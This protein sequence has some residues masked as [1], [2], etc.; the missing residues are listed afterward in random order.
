MFRIINKISARYI[1]AATVIFHFLFPLHLL[2]QNIEKNDSLID[3]LL[4]SFNYPSVG[5]VFV[6]GKYDYNSQ[7]MFIPVIEMFSILGIYV[8]PSNSGTQGYING[9]FLIG[10]EPYSFDFKNYKVKVGKVEKIFSADDMFESPLDSYASVKIFEEMFQMI[11]NYSL[12]NL[13]LTLNTSLTMPVVDKSSR[14]A[15]RERIERLSRSRSFYPLEY[16]RKRSLLS[17]GFLDYNVG[18][19]S[20]FQSIIQQDYTF[21]MVGGIEALGGEVQASNS[22]AYSEVGG[23]SNR[24]GNISWKYSVR[25]TPILSSI[26]IGQISTRGLQSQQINGVSFTNNPIEPRWLYGETVVDGNAQAD[27]EVELYLNNELIDFAISDAQGYYRFNVPLRYGTTSLRTQ[28]YTTDGQLIVNQKEIQIPF[29]FLPKGNLSYNIQAGLIDRD[30]GIQNYGETKAAN[31]DLSYG[32]SN[33][34]TTKV[35]LEYSDIDVD[36]PLIYGS[37]TARVFQQYLLN[38]EFVPSS[39]YRAQ[40]SVVF[41]SNHSISAVYTYFDGISRFNRNGAEHQLTTNIYSPIPLKFLN[42]GLRVSADYTKISSFSETRLRTDF[43]SQLGPFNL[44]L[45]YSD[46]L[47]ASKSSLNLTGG[48]LTSALTYKFNRRSGLKF[49]AGSFLR[50]SMTYNNLSKSIQQIDLQLSKTVL[51]RGQLSLGFSRVIPSKQSFLQ[52]GFNI[53]LGG[54]VRSST[55]G[56]SNFSSSSITQSFRGSIGYD[57]NFN[58]W[59]A[60]DRQQVS[61]SG[62]SVVMFVDNDNDGSYSKGDEIIP[63]PAIKLNRTA[64]VEVSKKGIV[65]LSQ[66]QSNYRYNLEI[67]RGQIPNPLFLPEKDKFSFIADPNQFKT[68]EIPFYRSGVI[69]GMVYQNIDGNEEGV[70]GL[71]LFVSGIDRDFQKTIRTFRGGSF[72]SLDIPPGRYTL[73]VDP[74]QLGYTG[75]VPRDGILEFQIK[76]TSEG[77]FLNDLEIVLIPAVPKDEIKPDINIEDIIANLSDEYQAYILELEKSIREA[78]LYY[79]SAQEAYFNGDFERA[80]NQIDASL[81]LYRTDYGIALKGTIHYLQGDEIEANKLWDEAYTR[82]P[83]IVKPSINDLK[84]FLRLKTN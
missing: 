12:N 77:D 17:A 32:I 63:Y 36:T 37:A 45:N 26:Q 50:T 8:E 1:L 61:K 47:I 23:W 13:S 25:D 15:A 57:D 28:V 71:R 83:N 64:Q 5:Q 42:A 67:D 82:N 51:Q 20:Q 56:R 18:I 4:L 84:N 40:S 39:L 59:Q 68:I 78:L 48:T 54:K 80:M 10:G 58:E 55:T 30:G 31:A 22:F 60:V 19:A 11:F 6:L 41:N 53:D 52:A 65:R 43:F 3:D 81:S 9:T 16:G 46:R 2:G 76:A 24:Y 66:L 79:T 35:G 44:R 75:T 27:S 14:D 7:N 49:L 62:A 74:V 70:G 38:M 73:E 72:Y 69:E 33:W 29:T 34:L 21:Q